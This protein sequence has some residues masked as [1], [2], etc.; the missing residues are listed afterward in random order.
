MKRN[1]NFTLIMM[2]LVVLNLFFV[3]RTVEAG[4]QKRRLNEEKYYAALEQTYVSEIREKL[5][6]YGITNS[7]INMT[8]V[9]DDGGTRCYRIVI[10]NR[11][12][13]WL[14]ADSLQ[15]LWT[16]IEGLTFP[17]DNCS[18]FHEFV[19]DKKL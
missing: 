15:Q 19:A 3:T 7:G 17:A 6:K 18:C 4:E 1:K 13:Q 16:E 2:A 14:A 9:S 5:Q 10:H 11:Q 12:L 8:Y